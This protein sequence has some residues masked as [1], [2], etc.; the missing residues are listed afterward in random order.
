M[1]VFANF[2]AAVAQV[3][4]LIL[5]VFYWLVLVRALISWVGPD[6]LNPIVQFLERV[7]EPILAP[8]RRLLPAMPIDISPLIA[9]VIILFLQKFLV[10]TLYDIGF[11]IR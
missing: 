8:I 11:A 4:D 10:P 1:F 5:K 7:T 2:F 3:I 9:F 6:P